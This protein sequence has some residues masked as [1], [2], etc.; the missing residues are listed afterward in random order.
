MVTVILEE[1][2]EK[3]YEE[4]E[5]EI[6]Q[7]IKTHEREF[8][9]INKAIEQLKNNIEFG[10]RISKKSPIFGYFAA[11]YD[12]DNL[13][14]IKTGDWRLFYTIRA[15]EVEVLAII[16]EHIDHKTYDRRGGY[17]TT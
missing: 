16:L 8:K 5:S 11:T 10:L 17:H 15:D 1:K 2:L 12:T 4:L 13:W 7:G 6:E 9:Q 3:R 14:M